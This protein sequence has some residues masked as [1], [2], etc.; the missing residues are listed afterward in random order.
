[1]LSKVFAAEPEPTYERLCAML[2]NDYRT[3]GYVES[4][5]MAISSTK[6][7]LKQKIQKGKIPRGYCFRG[8]GELWK[9]GHQCND[10]FHRAWKSE[11]GS[12][13]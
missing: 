11:N 2:S 8:C 13:A 6:P 4:S 10:E 9:K 12:R 7:S 1:M 5:L 3:D